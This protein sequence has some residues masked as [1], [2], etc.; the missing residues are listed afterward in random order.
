MILYDPTSNDALCQ[1][2]QIHCRTAFIMTKLGKVPD[3]VNEIRQK[4]N[5]M[6]AGKYDIIDADSFTTG[7]DLFTKIWKCIT[8]VPIG[9]AIIYKGISA[10]T[11]ANIFMELGML[12]AYGKETLIIK[13]GNVRIPSDLSGIEYVGY[14]MDFERH[15]NHFL[16]HLDAAAEYYIQMADM[17]ENDPFLAIDYLRR[18]YM[19]NGDRTLCEKARQVFDSANQTDRSK[20]SVEALAMSYFK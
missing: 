14:D 2:R 6:L 4:L 18:A 7:K 20:R 15:M 3:I 19:L 11:L 1:P 8:S 12:H 10:K 17:I 5:T 13:S 16:D 9:I